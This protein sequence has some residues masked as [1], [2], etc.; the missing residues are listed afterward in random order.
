MYLPCYNENT[1]HSKN[2]VLFFVCFQKEFYNDL[3]KQ[4]L[5][6]KMTLDEKLVLFGVSY[7]GLGFF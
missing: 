5:F 1:V 6:V 7:I 3:M 4:V 2:W